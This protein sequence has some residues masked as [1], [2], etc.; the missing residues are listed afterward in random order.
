MPAGPFFA[1]HPASGRRATGAAALLE[2]RA[3]SAAVP[4]PRAAPPEH[5]DPLLLRVQ[6]GAGARCDDRV[7]RAGRGQRAGP[8]AVRPAHPLVWLAERLLPLCGAGPAVVPRLAARA[9]RVC[10]CR[11]AGA[12]AAR[13]G[14]RQG[15][16]GGSGRHV[17]GAVAEQRSAAAPLAALPGDSTAQYPGTSTCLPACLPGAERAALAV[18][19]SPPQA[20]CPSRPRT[21]PG[22]SSCALRPYGL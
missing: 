7:W 17:A 5:W 9:T 3:A 22:A 20:M 16:Q 8:A 4:A 12:A 10:G 15:G 2:R 19:P 14:G 11:R 1:W 21:C 18:P 6:E 13:Q